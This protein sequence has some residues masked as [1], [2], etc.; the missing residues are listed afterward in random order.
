MG[1][2]QP[3]SAHA[4][5][6]RHTHRNRPHAP[7]ATSRWHRQATCPNP[8]R[9]VHG[10]CPQTPPSHPSDG[11]SPRSLVPPTLPPVPPWGR[12]TTGSHTCFSSALCGRSTIVAFK[13]CSAVCIGGYSCLL[14]SLRI[15]SCSII[16]HFFVVK[17]IVLSDAQF[18]L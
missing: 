18:Q 2:S 16:L 1:Q 15:G 6:H 12:R 9:V 5:L 3:Y 11:Q 8:L 7:T 17:Q 14:C 10:L 4:C 13:I